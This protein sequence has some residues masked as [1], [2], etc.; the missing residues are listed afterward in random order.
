MIN[1]NPNNSYK[2]K[3]KFTGSYTK[4]NPSHLNILPILSKTDAKRKLKLQKLHRPSP[5]P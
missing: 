4:V 5:V 2:T 3:K 1:P